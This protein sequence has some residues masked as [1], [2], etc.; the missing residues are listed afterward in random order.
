[1]LQEKN[2]STTGFSDYKLFFFLR[3]WTYFACQ[4]SVPKPT[5]TIIHTYSKFLMQVMRQLSEQEPI[6]EKNSLHAIVK[7]ILENLT[8]AAVER[9]SILINDIPS[10]FMVDA[11]KNKLSSL[12]NIVL[13]KM[14]MHGKDSCYRLS[15]RQY[16]NIILLQVKNTG[17]RSEF[18]NKYYT[19]YANALCQ[20]LGGC[21]SMNEFHNHAMSL[22]FSF[23]SR[24]TAA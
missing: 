13:S 21:I 7:R 3:K 8:A 16:S 19:G 22:T 10:S 6:H 1:M 18:Y 5:I 2:R 12:L 4:F 15:A 17:S 14:I 9:S 24:S 11:D 20:T 23:P